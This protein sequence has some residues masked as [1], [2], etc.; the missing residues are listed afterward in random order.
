M[1]TSAIRIY[2]NGSAIISSVTDIHID[3]NTFVD[4]AIQ[5]SY[6]AV[7]WLN[8]FLPNPSTTNC[9]FQN[10]IIYNCGGPFQV[11]GPSPQVGIALRSPVDQGW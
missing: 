2:A 7:L 6:G 4:A 1:G 9:S 10:N 5:D 3:N 8:G 11:L